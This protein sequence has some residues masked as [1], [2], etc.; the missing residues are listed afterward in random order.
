MWRYYGTIV[1]CGYHRRLAIISGVFVVSLA[2]ECASQ[3]DTTATSQRAS[4]KA[5]QLGVGL[6]GQGFGGA[7]M[8]MPMV[9]L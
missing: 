3:P 6:V 9:A 4:D 7:R 1:H 8:S 5:V 2:A